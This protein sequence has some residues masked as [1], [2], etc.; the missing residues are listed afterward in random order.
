MPLN[1]EQLL[2]SQH[3]T[4]PCMVLSG[5]GSGKTTVITK[6]VELL[7]KTYQVPPEQILVITFTKAAAAELQERFLYHTKT[8][9][10]AVTFGTFHAVFYQILRRE[11]PDKK[12]RLLTENERLI[13]FTEV[14]RKTH[15]DLEINSD[16]AFAILSELSYRIN[17]QKSFDNSQYKQID[18]QKA[19]DEFSKRKKQEEFLDFDD[20]LSETKT[21]LEKNPES[22]LYWQKRFGF[23]LID[24]F[25]DINPIQYDIVRM[26]ARPR[27][28]LFIVGDD[29]QSIYAFRGA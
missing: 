12:F 29:D 20:L 17:H 2:A 6:R 10:T 23:L 26:L 28:N 27:N 11:N 22:L 24:E 15:P 13:L 8:Q 19:K 9:K 7:I 14:L 3:Y 18:F 16:I 25:Q 21:V 5:P 4:N 1:H